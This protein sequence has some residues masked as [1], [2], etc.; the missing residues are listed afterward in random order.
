[1]TLSRKDA[2]AFIE[3]R[4]GRV[5]G[6]V[7]GNTDYLVVGEDPGSKLDRATELGVPRIDEA[8][9]RELSEAAGDRT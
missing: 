8:G 6:S 7:S 2:K 1:P 4:G 9:L 5:T 3:Q